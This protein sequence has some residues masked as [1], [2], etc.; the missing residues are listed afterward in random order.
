MSVT[1]PPPVPSRPF[2]T[3]KK[4]LNGTHRQSRPSRTDVR[5]GLKAFVAPLV[6]PGIGGLHTHPSRVPR[7]GR[8]PGTRSRKLRRRRAPGPRARDMGTASLRSHG[9]HEPSL[10][11]EM[12]RA[13]VLPSYPRMCPREMEPWDLRALSAG[14]DG[15]A[16]PGIWLCAGGRVIKTRPPRFH[17]EAGGNRGAGGRRPRYTWGPC[18]LCWC[19]PPLRALGHCSP[20]PRD[21][22]PCRARAPEAIACARPRRCKRKLLS[23]DTARVTSGPLQ[24]AG[25]HAP[26]QAM[27]ECSGH[28]DPYPPWGGGGGRGGGAR[29]R[30]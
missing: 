4:P 24:S 7:A 11:S 8:S 10:Q 2:H 15:G 5:G 26:E 9:P 22:V 28:P 6:G 3:P 20:A 19:P 29:V 12:V 14:D 30:S 18:R 17:R 1:L 13:M 16:A 25:P 21:G 23:R 27:A